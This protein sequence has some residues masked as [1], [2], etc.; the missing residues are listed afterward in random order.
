[1]ET[2]SRYEVIADLEEKKRA[3]IR[4]RDGLK[5]ELI[6]K[7]TLVKTY[8]R[9]LEDVGVLVTDFTREYKAKVEDLQR[10]ESEF[11]QKIVNT[12]TQFSRQIEDAKDDVKNFKESIQAK[13]KTAEELIEQVDKSL[14]KFNLQSQK[15]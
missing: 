8:E 13:K 12:K 3:I 5:D 14:E 9:K 15:K 7:Q 4:E 11:K 10:E 1:M 6:S 2:K